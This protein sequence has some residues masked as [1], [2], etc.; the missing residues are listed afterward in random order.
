M[1]RAG[2]HLTA[3][4]SVS[5]LNTIPLALQGVL[6]QT[7]KLEATYNGAPKNAPAVFIAKF[8]NPKPEFAFFRWILGST[9][10]M[11][12]KQED[13]MYSHSFFEKMGVR[14][15]KCYFT[16]YDPTREVFCLLMEDLNMA[17]SALT[18]SSHPPL[19]LE[20]SG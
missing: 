12:F 20:W 9:G 13:W 1:L 16:S 19:G 8:L 5:T 2:G 14:Q 17:G 3:R 11:S 4:Q 10:L 7:F 6:S 18:H 15:P